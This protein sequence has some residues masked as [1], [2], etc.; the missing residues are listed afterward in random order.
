MLKWFRADLHIHTCLS[1]CCDLSMSP[2]SIVAEA[3]RLGL[4]IIAITDHNSAANVDAVMR[5]ADGSRVSVLPGL[6]VCTRE[7]VHVVALFDKPA[8]AQNLQREVYDHLSGQNDPDVIG[9]QVIA[10][11]HDE[12]EGFEERLLIG[13]ADFSVDEIVQQIHRLGGL[14]IAAHID[15]ESFGI[16]GQ[17]GF[18]PPAVRFDAL[19]LSAT[20]S[21]EEAGRRFAEYKQ[22]QF[23][24]NS[25]AHSRSQLGRTGTRFL[26]EQPTCN[27]LRLALLRVGGRM[28]CPELHA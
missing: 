7:E 5:A 11:E 12:V 17:L 10:N 18:I 3:L 8:E 15:R 14:A 20:I 23:L 9:M 19:E 1:P 4:G 27:E 22:H 13:A 2:R 21:D 6:E 25:D 28:A 24:R 26:L 16:V